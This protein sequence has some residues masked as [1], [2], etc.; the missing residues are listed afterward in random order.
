VG[1]LVLFGHP[2][3]VWPSSTRYI[4]KSG[5]VERHQ[6]YDNKVQNTR[7]TEELEKDPRLPLLKEVMALYCARVKLAQEWSAFPFNC[8]YTH[9]GVKASKRDNRPFGWPPNS[10]DQVDWVNRNTKLWN[11]KYLANIFSERGT[12]CLVPVLHGYRAGSC[13]VF[14]EV[15]RT[16]LQYNGGK[17]LMKPARLFVRRGVVEGPRCKE[18]GSLVKLV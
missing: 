11:R 18:G 15:R 5:A 17:S 14:D 3:K 16:E 9:M 4:G 6:T 1:C 10:A 8:P 2:N 13:A 7:G 12:L